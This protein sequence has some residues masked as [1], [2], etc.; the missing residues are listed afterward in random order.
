M[1][2]FDR[3]SHEQP[4]WAAIVVLLILAVLGWWL[5]P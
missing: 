4:S 2:H 5:I 1:S 3:Q